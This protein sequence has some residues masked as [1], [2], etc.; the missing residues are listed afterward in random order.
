MVTSSKKALFLA[1]MTLVGLSAG[2]AEAQF[3]IG[4]KGVSFGKGGLRSIGV[5]PAALPRMRQTADLPPQWSKG[6][7]GL[8]SPVHRHWVQPVPQRPAVCPSTPAPLPGPY[9]PEQPPEP[10]APATE[11]EPSPALQLTYQ[12]QEAFAQGD[13]QSAAEFMNQVIELSPESAAAYQFRALSH[14]ALQQHDQAAA[15]VYDALLRGPIWTW[16]TVFPLYGDAQVYT[17]QYRE[18]S[19]AA[20]QD[21]DSMSKHFLLAYHHLMLGHLEHGAKELNKV[22]SIQPE[23]PVTQKLLAVVEQLQAKER[24]AQR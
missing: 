24:V 19:A 6:R 8:P 4:S 14:F 1:A 12:A 15:D 2:L 11:P 22:L 20:K 21:G 18:L 7:R 3:S 17:R 13:Y 23:Q 9:V 16:K 5:S 10:P